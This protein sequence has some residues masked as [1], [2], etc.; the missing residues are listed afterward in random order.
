MYVLQEI[1]L[2]L[3]LINGSEVLALDCERVYLSLDT[4]Y[5]SWWVV[6][7]PTYF[8]IW[9]FVCGMGMAFLDKNDGG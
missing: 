7:I 8:M 2:I 5:F 6:F 9:T 1:H 3:K 4:D